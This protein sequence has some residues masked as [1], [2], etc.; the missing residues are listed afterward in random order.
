MAAPSGQRAARVGPSL[1]AARKRLRLTQAQVAHAAHV[2][3]TTVRN[4]EHDA[5]ATPHREGFEAVCEVLGLDPDDPVSSVTDR[6]YSRM[7][8]EVQLVIY[9]L[10]GWLSALPDDRRQVEI[11]GLMDRIFPNPRHGD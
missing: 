8:R 4:L 2:S 5:F 11:D 1:R 7:P 6:V 10:G 3:I 9:A